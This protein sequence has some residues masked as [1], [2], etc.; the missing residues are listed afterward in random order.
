M[1]RMYLVVTA[2]LIAVSL[3]AFT[4]KNVDPPYL[5]L[6]DFEEWTEVPTGIDVPTVCPPSN[7]KQCKIQIAGQLRDIFH[8]DQSPYM[9]D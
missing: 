1:K 7:V 6:D 2:A 9:R 3:S 8:S 5:Y 4:S